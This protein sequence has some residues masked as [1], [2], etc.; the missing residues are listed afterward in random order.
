[1]TVASA[2]GGAGSNMPYAPDMTIR[3]ARPER[4]K[5]TARSARATVAAAASPSTLTP[6]PR[7]TMTS[8]LSEDTGPMLLETPRARNPEATRC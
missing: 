2:R 5:A 1:M 7:A 8:A 4:Y 6:P 3:G